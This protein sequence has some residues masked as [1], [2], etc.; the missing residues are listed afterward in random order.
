MK[1]SKKTVIGMAVVIV[2]MGAMMT[3]AKAESRGYMTPDFLTV[4]QDVAKGW[5]N[6]ASWVNKSDD[7]DALEGRDG[8]A[9]DADH[10][11]DARQLKDI[12]DGDVATQGDFNIQI[13]GKNY[14]AVPAASY[15]EYLA[16]KGK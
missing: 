13:D 4:R 8:E 3:N 2:A 9:A 15:L 14:V 5:V 11:Q 10:L 7:Q 6:R 12:R 16:E 1:Q